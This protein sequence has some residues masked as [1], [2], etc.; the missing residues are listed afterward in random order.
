MGALKLK[1]I[2]PFA[3]VGAHERPLGTA[4]LSHSAAADSTRERGEARAC[5]VPTRTVVIVCRRFHGMKP[6]YSLKV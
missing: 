6:S 2:P 3:A 1:V 5:P 4:G